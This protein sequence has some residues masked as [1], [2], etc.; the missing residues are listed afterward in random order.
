[1]AITEHLRV[2]ATENRVCV[3]RILEADVRDQGVGME[4]RALMMSPCQIAL[5]QSV[6]ISLQ[7][8]SFRDSGLTL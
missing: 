1:M 2:S 6:A 4:N 7:P 3:L 5:F 8:L